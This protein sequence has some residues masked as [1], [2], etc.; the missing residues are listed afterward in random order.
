MKSK[1]HF[2]AFQIYGLEF[3]MAAM[4]FALQIC[5]LE[6]DFN[7]SSVQTRRMEFLAPEVVYNRTN[8]TYE[9]NDGSKC[10]GLTICLLATLNVIF[11]VKKC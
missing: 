11:W 10:V 2:L 1:S 5:H 9:L 8:S 6:M 4:A 3:G 7:A